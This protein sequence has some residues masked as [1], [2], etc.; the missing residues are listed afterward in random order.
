MDYKLCKLRGSRQESSEAVPEMIEVAGERE[1]GS[2]AFL[3]MY[4]L[5]KSELERN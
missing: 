3:K 5:Q 1:D 2:G 4:K